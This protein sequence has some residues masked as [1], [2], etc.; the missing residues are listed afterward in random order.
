MT[1]NGQIAP[2]TFSVVGR[3]DQPIHQKSA[4]IVER[5]DVQPGDDR[6]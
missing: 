5:R 6:G 2:P 3:N 4:I 1:E